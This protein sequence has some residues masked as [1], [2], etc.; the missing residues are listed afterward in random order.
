M[1][2][3]NRHAYERGE[4]LSKVHAPRNVEE[5]MARR[6]DGKVGELNRW[7]DEMRDET[8]ESITTTT[9]LP[10]TTTRRRRRPASATTSH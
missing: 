7:V 4:L 1:T 10:A 5:R 3:W 2:V 8:A 9:R 6:Y